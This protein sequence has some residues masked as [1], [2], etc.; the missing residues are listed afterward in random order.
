V[1]ALA[2][3]LAGVPNPAK[4][5]LGV[6]AIGIAGFA[7]LTALQL[8]FAPWSISLTGGPTLTGE[9]VG[10]LDLPA[11]GGLM[12]WFELDYSD[13]NG[14]HCD[15]CPRI[16]GRG[17]SCDDR[18]K[19][20]RSELWGDVEDW[21]GRQSWLKARE[22]EETRGE[23]RLRYLR[24]EWNGGDALSLT[25]TLVAPGVPTTTRWERTEAGEESITQIGGHP[26]TRAP[27]AFSLARGTQQD[28][29]THCKA[30][31]ER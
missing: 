13:Q 2:R 3:T 18:G 11:G 31:A 12:V 15:N 14:M 10:K 8:V 28:F 16:E 25:T 19:A 29:E 5:A 1:R 6:A 17:A 23:A 7:A 27:V 21:R 24:A 30:K 22:V 9:W 26:D 4:F 20:V